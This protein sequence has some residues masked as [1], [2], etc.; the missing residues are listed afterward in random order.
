MIYG[1][2][3]VVKRN[4]APGQTKNYLPLENTLKKTMKILIVL[5]GLVALVVAALVLLTPWMDRWGA[6]DEEI[7]AVYP[8]DELLAVPASF[9]NRAVTIHTTPEKIYP[10]IVQLGA[11]KGGYYSYS[12]FE[13]NLLNCRL[14]NADQIHNEWQ[15]LKVGDQVTMCPGNSGPPPYTV[16]MIKPDQAVV[17]GHQENGKWV[18]LWQFV[19]VPQTDGS[20]RLILRTRT[21]AVGGFWNVIHPGVFIMERGM[22]LGIRDRAEANN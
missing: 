8:G 3:G 17:L 14:V 10:W 9:V 12:W 7:A 15:G 1:V 6:T 20:S 2:I 4:K 5:I 13:T 18:D 22:L 21:N 16:A 11:G 19:I